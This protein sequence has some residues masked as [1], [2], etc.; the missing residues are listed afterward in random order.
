[1]FLSAYTTY[2]AYYMTP[3]NTHLHVV[4]LAF[5]LALQ[6][7]SQ[8][9]LFAL[10]PI[11]N[12]RRATLHA[13]NGPI[14]PVML[15]SHV[16]SDSRVNYSSYKEVAKHAAMLMFDDCFNLMKIGTGP[17]HFICDMLVV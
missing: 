3:T 11:Y 8:Y 17:Y 9:R 1:M 4:Y 16:F 12:F 2:H 7:M 5:M 15:H 13:R 6:E 10:P 14:L